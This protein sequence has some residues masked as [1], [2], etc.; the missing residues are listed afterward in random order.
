MS[1]GG[2]LL[3][4]CVFSFK[5]QATMRLDEIHAV[6]IRYRMANKERVASI[7]NP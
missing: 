5:V 7:R 6:T 2:S 4:S 3:E 1:A